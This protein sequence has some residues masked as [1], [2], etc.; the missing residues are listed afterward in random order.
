M[1]QAITKPKAK[2]VTPAEIQERFGLSD[3][4]MADLIEVSLVKGVSRLLRIA[5]AD[6][7]RRITELIGWMEHIALEEKM[8]SELRPDEHALFSGLEMHTDTIALLKAA[9]WSNTEVDLKEVARET[10]GNC[11][12]LENWA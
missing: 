7:H 4:V 9:P 12:P 10:L 5:A 8:E 1:S 3:Q 2:E 6:N 11:D